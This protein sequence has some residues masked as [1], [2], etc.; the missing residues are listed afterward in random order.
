VEP[1]FGGQ[2]FMPLAL[3]R[4]SLLNKEILRQ[5]VATLIEVDG[6]INEITG[7][8]CVQAGANI[9]VVGNY[10]FGHKDIE[11]RFKALKG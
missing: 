10:L 1:G 4:I 3:E 8:A 11:K 5:G 7:P 9:L 6:G 2:S